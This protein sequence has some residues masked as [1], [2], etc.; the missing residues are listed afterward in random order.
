MR[1]GLL[2]AGTFENV[3]VS[4]CVFRD[5]EDSGL[6]IQLCEGGSMRNMTFSNLVMSNVPRPVFMTFNR[7][8]AGVDT[9]DPAP[10]MGQ[11]TN[12]L[13]D[14]IRVDSDRA[15]T[16][17]GID[18]AFVLTGVP[19]K[20]IGCVSLSNI[21]FTAPGGY[22][23]GE[24][25]RSPHGTD[26]AVFASSLPEPDAPDGG[27]ELV[28]RPSTAP[29][30]A[31]YSGPD[32]DSPAARFS[33]GHAEESPRWPEYSKLGRPVPASGVYARHVETL[34]LANCRFATRRPDSRPAVVCE[35]VPQTSMS[36]VLP[37]GQHEG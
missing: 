15:E 30:L 2:S 6:K 27:R 3:T 14:T 35:D 13:F 31:E 8:R 1:I 37:C 4:N 34:I 7:Q 19:G 21:S 33:D 25:I 10:A 32:E 28:L 24:T 5:S 12:F 29:E 16:G 23:D 20:R 26:R 36:G 22:G 9:P 17:G 11:M 18:S